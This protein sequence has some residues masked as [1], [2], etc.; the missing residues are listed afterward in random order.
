MLITLNIEAYIFLCSLIGGAVIAFLYDI[1]RIKR[2]AIKTSAIFIY[3]EDLIFWIIV[4]IVMFGVVYYGNDGEIRGY[5]F[6]GTILGVTLYSVI[7]SKIV[8]AISLFII[9]IIYKIFYTIWNILTYP[10]RILVRFLA[11]PL[12]FIFKELFK[13]TRKSKRIFKN[14]LKKV[15]NVNKLFKKI[16][17]KI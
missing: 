2:K 17:R 15:L 5:I 1:F 9:K 14:G 6:L 8:M 11:I 10:I 4:A 16:K 3:F 12:G 13:I 7:F